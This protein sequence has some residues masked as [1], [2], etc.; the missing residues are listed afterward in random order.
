MPAS[1]WR[2]SQLDPRLRQ[3]DSA[4][5]RD[6]PGDPPRERHQLATRSGRPLSRLRRM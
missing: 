2:R 4:R 3:G 5:R 6:R 1:P